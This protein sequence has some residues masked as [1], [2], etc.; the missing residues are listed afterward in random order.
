MSTQYALVADLAQ[1]AANPT[2]LNG[3]PSTDQQA[4]LDAASAEADGYLAAQYQLPLVSWGTPLRMHVCN[5]AMYRLMARRGY[6]PGGADVS[7]KERYDEAIAWLRGVSAGRVTPPDLIDSSPG[8]VRQG[9]PG[10]VTGLVGN[11]VGGSATPTV[12][13]GGSKPYPYTGTI[14]GQRGWR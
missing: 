6:R 5:M 9:A 13:L 1:L 12:Q 14:P 10:V 4:A 8:G 3:I 11:T 2:S 7:F